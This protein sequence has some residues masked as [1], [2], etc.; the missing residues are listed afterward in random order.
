MVDIV[1]SAVRWVTRLLSAHRRKTN[2]L[3]VEGW[4]IGPMSVGR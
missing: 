3:G 1:S 4:G 2:V